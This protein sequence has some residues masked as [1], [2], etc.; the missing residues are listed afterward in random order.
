VRSATSE[1]PAFAGFA[2]DAG[3]LVEEPHAIAERLRDLL[4]QDDWLAHADRRPGTDRYR[5]HILH[6]SADRRLSVVA[7]VWRP[8]QYTPIHDHVA[9]CIVGVYRGVER[10]ERY[11]LVE[12]GGR[13]F[14]QPTGSILARPGHVETLV[15]P[16]EEDIHAV[17]A[18]GEQTAISIHVYGAD[19]EARGSSI[20]RL[21]DD[22]PQLAAA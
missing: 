4:G 17:S 21:Y 6:V 18:A 14:L 1:S 22:V 11:R 10:E 15:P 16:F 20:L 19:I 7:L 12:S 13:S 2:A 5:Q 9:W 8:G 3:R